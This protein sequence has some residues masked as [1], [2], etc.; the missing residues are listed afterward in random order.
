MKALSLHAVLLLPLLTCVLAGCG[1]YW[2]PPSLDP[3]S[4]VKYGDLRATY[5]SHSRQ[6]GEELARLESERA[7]PLLLQHDAQLASEDLVPERNAAAALAVI[8]TPKE[9]EKLPSELAKYYPRGRFRFHPI[10]LEA[11][12]HLRE[13]Y[14]DQCRAFR[15]AIGCPACDFQ[16]QLT[17]G[18]M[19]DVSFVDVATA[20]NRFEGVDAAR[21]LRSG[22][23]DAATGSLDRMLRVA[24]FLAQEK[25]LVPRLAAV[26]LRGEAIA[27][28]EA[29]AQHPAASCDTHQQ[30]AEIL[31][32]QLE[33][34]PP[35]ANAWV[36]DRAIG[37]HAYEMIRDGHLLSIL[38]W[39]EIK[40]YSRRS[41]LAAVSSAVLESIDNDE[42]FYLRSMRKII[43]SSQRPYFERKKTLAEVSRELERLK[44][45][46]DYP[47]VADKILL[48]DVERGHY[49][50]ALDRARCEAWALALASAAALPVPTPRV[51]PLD[52]HPYRIEQEQKRIVVR[53][54]D[55]ERTGPIIVPISAAPAR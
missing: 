18:L 14:A 16:I 40:E 46:G 32:S 27:L 37:L 20:G 55:P 2:Q 12:L 21:S 49:L 10:A 52:G 30:L 8:F 17:R 43:D 35:D 19:A 25:H 33:R 48:A 36:G 1:R 31:R 51:N 29:I 39:D 54:E 24:E 22:A 50:Q 42:M 23:L 3:A 9:I 53:I 34:W 15:Q 5:Q 28:L 38:T 44:D 41:E 13:K 6:L 26:R 45:T 47:I 7:T 11:A 4:L